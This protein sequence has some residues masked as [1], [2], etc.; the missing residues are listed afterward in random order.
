MK[1]S[2]AL[3]NA[4]VAILTIQAVPIRRIPAGEVG[5]EY[6]RIVQLPAVNQEDVEKAVVVVVQQGHSATH[7]F[8]QVF[9]RR[10]GIAMREIDPCGVGGG[11]E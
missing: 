1:A 8:D 10:R 5:G 3:L 6:Y 2:H 11:V 9:L 7:G 4:L